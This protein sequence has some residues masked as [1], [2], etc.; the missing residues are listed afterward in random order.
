[1]FSA[2]IIPF[3]FLATT[4]DEAQA[5]GWHALDVILVTGDSYVISIAP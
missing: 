4:L 3:M 1:M 5:L 2:D